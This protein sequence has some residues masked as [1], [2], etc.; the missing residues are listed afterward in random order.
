V[1]ELQEYAEHVREA[2]ADAPVRRTSGCGCLGWGVGAVV[3]LLIAD[4]AVHIWFPLLFVLIMLVV[5]G[6]ALTLLINGIRNREAT[7]GPFD[8][9]N[10]DWHPLA[11]VRSARRESIA[12]AAQLRTP[13]AAASPDPPPAAPPADPAVSA[14][15]AGLG[16]ADAPAPPEP[17]PDDAGPAATAAA[18]S[19]EPPEAPQAP[20]TPD[21]A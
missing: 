21:W 1:D 17:A 6:T 9:H 4:G 8:P 11:V 5:A 14:A 19:P 3:L 12:R 20:E 7:R 15:A 2:H 10:V 16:P 13:P 18:Y